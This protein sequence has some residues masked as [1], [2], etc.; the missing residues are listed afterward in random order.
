M[1]TAFSSNEIRAAC[2][3]LPFSYSLSRARLIIIEH[4]GPVE[5]VL[6]DEREMRMEIDAQIQMR[7]IDRRWQ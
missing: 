2:V 4:N 7:L 1:W 3:P 6:L 5:R